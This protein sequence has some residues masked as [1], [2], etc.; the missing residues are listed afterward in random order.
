LPLNCQVRRAKVT[1]L[2]TNGKTTTTPP[3]T[4]RRRVWATDEKSW[5][6][7]LLNFYISST[8]SSCKHLIAR[9]WVTLMARHWPAA[10]NE[11]SLSLSLSTWHAFNS[12]TSPRRPRVNIHEATT[13]TLQFFF[14][15]GEFFSLSKSII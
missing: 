1:P 8:Y 15:G 2:T 13:T 12:R 3:P 5:A 9:S 6:R 14:F 4:R 11:E 7:R 10:A